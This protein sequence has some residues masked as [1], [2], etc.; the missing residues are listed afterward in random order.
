MTKSV[1]KPA[2]A[3]PTRK[4]R[5]TPAVTE[6]VNAGRPGSKS[7]LIQELLGRQTGATI[8]ELAAASGWQDHSVRGFM[9][10]TLEEETRT[11]RY[12]P[13]RRRSSAL[14]AWQRDCRP[15][16]MLT[17]KLR[18]LR[19]SAL[20]ISVALGS[21]IMERAPGIDEQGTAAAGH[22][23]QDA[24][25]GVRRLEPPDPAATS[26][27]AS[28]PAGK[29]HTEGSSQRPVPKAGTTLVRE[30]QGKVHEVLALEDGQFACGGKTYPSLTV[31]A[32]QITGTHQSGPRFFGLKPHA[33][34]ASVKG[35]R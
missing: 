3:K 32:R 5:S 12:D 19:T 34:V 22:R 16:T 17:V 13:D 8:K 7:Y 14:P 29:R 21:S 25:G 30:W 10:V 6:P 9:S 35:N 20:P 18:A 11:C 28:A 31:I 33:N 2:A 26:S 27:L 1:K 24:R 15:V 4:P 23:V